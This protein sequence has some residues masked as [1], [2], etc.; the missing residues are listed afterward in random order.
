MK[1]LE[2]FANI[3]R[4]KINVDKNNDS[5][6]K[7][8]LKTCHDVGLQ[9]E[10]EWFKLLGDKLNVNLNDNR[11]GNLSFHAFFATYSMNPHTFFLQVYN[12]K[13]L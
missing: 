1:T 3:S 11:N 13:A 4:L 5:T 10:L 6:N 2:K 9:W 8:N 7:S 12:I